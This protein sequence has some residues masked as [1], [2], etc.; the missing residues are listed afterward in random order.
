MDMTIRTHLI[1]E[2]ILTNMAVPAARVL[3]AA[4]LRTDLGLD[5]IDIGELGCKLDVVLGVVTS[6]AD[7]E[8]IRTVQD[9]MDFIGAELGKKNLAA[10]LPQK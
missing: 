5:S 6:D 3:P 1:A 2:G 4:R 8:K 7:M 9:L 10:G